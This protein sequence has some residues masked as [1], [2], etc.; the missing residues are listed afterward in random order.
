[1][2]EKRH[3]LIFIAFILPKHWQIFVAY[4]FVM[5]RGLAISMRCHGSCVR[6]ISFLSGR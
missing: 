5:H 4:C 3:W 6:K 2:S 1:M